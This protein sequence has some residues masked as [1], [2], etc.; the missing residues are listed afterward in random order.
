MLTFHERDDASVNEVSTLYK[1]VLFIGWR[2][3]ELGMVPFMDALLGPTNM[4]TSPSVHSS[5][6]GAQGSV[7]QPLAVCDPL[8]THG[9][10]AWYCRSRE[11]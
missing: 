7:L 10:E 6:R 1:A 9:P 11:R 4:Q 5:A 2:A 8:D 3:F